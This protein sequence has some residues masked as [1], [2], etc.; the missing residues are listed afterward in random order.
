MNNEET[1]VL[2]IDNVVVFPKN[3]IRLDIDNN[4]N[5]D[6]LSNIDNTNSKELIIV[7]PIDFQS[8]DITSLPKIWSFS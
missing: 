7:N 5:R 6:I 3:E 2:V 8:S 1:I 4:F